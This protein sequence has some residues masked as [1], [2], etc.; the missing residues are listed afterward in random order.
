MIDY[1]DIYVITA[2]SGTGKTTINRR[3]IEEV[4]NIEISISHTTRKQRPG[5]VHGDHYWFIGT[6]EFENLIKENKMIEWAKVFGNYYGTSFFE[7]DR[8]SKKEHKISTPAETK[9]LSY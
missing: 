6:G 4:K 3:L 2:P 5:E 9:V 7:L 8:I 1:Q